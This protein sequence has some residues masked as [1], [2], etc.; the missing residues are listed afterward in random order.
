MQRSFD[1]REAEAAEGTGEG[2]LNIGLVVDGVF[3]DTG[4]K[5]GPMPELVKAQHVYMDANKNEVILRL[6]KAGAKAMQQHDVCSSG[7]NLL[8]EQNSRKKLPKSRAGNN[9]LKIVPIRSTIIR[10]IPISTSK[11]TTGAPLVAHCSKVAEGGCCTN[12]L[13]NP[14]VFQAQILDPTFKRL[15]IIKS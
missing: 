9:V 5:R 11:T 15:F 13:I 3:D 2:N 8:L 12:L 6:A 14:G 1:G 4:R 10:A 7:A